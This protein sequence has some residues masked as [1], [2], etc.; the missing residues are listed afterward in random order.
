MFYGGDIL[1]KYSTSKSFLLKILI[2]VSIFMYTCTAICSAHTITNL[3]DNAKKTYVILIDV[4]DN[5]MGIFENGTLIKIYNIASGKYSTPSPLGTWKIV[6]KDTWGE[7]FGGYFMGFNVPWGKYGIH[8]TIFPGSIGW[9]SSH[10]C[11]R[12]KNSDVRELY[13]KIPYGTTVIIK[14]DYLGNTGPYFRI[15]KPG[16]RGSDVYEVQRLLKQKGYFKGAQDGVYGGYMKSA[17]HK[18]QKDTNI[19]VSDNIYT[20]FYKKLGLLLMD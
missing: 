6:L 9:N 11:I 15:L 10:G 17:V 19:S 16:M 13:H 4:H 2:F 1:M 5:T 18:F 14:S 20:S 12:M 7:G 3:H 8:G